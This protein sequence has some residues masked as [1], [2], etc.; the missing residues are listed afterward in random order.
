M[1][2]P[3][4]NCITSSMFVNADVDDRVADPLDHIHRNPHRP[5]QHQSSQIDQAKA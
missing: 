5:S 4:L 3:L 1:S 2:A